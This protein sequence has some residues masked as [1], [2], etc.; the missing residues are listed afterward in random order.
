MKEFFWTYIAVLL[1]G[2]LGEIPLI[3]RF[4]DRIEAKVKQTLQNA[5]LRAGRL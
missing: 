2:F 5:A 1:G 3:K 4:F